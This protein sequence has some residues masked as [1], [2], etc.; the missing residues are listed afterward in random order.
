MLCTLHG[1]N[2]VG[3]FVMKEAAMHPTTMSRKSI[4]QAVAKR[5]NLAARP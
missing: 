5:S 2:Q 4:W 3:T 1:R